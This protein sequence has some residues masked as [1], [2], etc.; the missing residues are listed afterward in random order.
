MSEEILEGLE[1]EEQSVEETEESSDVQIQA[2]AKT[3]ASVKKEEEEDSEE[4]EDEE[5]MEEQKASVKKEE[6]E[7]DDSDDEEEEEP[8]EEA[9]QIPKTKNQMLK[10]IY[11]QVNKMKKSDLSGK[12]EQI[13]K[14]ATQVV[15][16]E[17]EVKEETTKIQAVSP[18]EIEP[19]NVEDDV[20]ALVSGE[21][22]LSE[23]FKKKASTI[24]EAAV[25]A[26]VVDEVNKRMEDQQKEVEAS[27]EEFQKDLSEKVDGYLTYV[28]EE[29][30]KE[31]EIALE[32]G[33]KGEISE[34]FISGLKTLFEEHYID[35]PDEKYD[36]LEGQCNAL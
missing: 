15:K 9:V 5:E 25:H 21:E 16:E 14:A 17:E 6:G 22:G 20:E 1:S 29:W 13:L 28:V 35:V 36:V 19:P 24:F 26:K 23:D 12:Y 18:Q 7:E 2:E 10:N 34:D 33:L 31:N 3:K 11:D 30:M 27:K 8:A 32:R 4:D